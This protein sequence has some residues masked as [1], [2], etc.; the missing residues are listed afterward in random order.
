MRP[1]FQFRAFCIW[2]S[3]MFL[4]A[5]KTVAEV[6]S[7]AVTVAMMPVAMTAEVAKEVVRP[8]A[9]AASDAVEIIGDSD[10]RG[11]M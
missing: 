6:A 11:I 4:R 1:E 7:D 5:L 10:K 2:A 8:L 3:F 9:A